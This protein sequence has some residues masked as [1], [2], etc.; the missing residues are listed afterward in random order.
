MLHRSDV[1]ERV[2]VGKAQIVDEGRVVDVGVEVDDVQR[3]L[4]LEPLHDRIGDRVIAAKHHGQ[5]PLGENRLGEVGRVVERALHVGGPDVDIADIRNGPVGHLV[6]KV[7]V[8]GL[9][10]VEPERRIAANRSECSRIERGPM[11]EPARKG[12]PSSKGTP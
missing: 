1:A 7:G 9:G 10:V 2:G 8:A 5:R 12:E 4:V 11:R 6:G 3:R